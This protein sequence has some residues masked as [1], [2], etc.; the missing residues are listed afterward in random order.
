MSDRPRAGI[1]SRYVTSRLG[2][3]S[4]ASLP[5]RLIEYQLGWG[6]GGNVTSA[7]WQVSLCDPTWHVS[8]RSGVAASLTA[9]P[10][11][12]TTSLRKSYEFAGLFTAREPN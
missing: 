5:G 9:V 8:T 4:L 6:K 12:F 1:S 10:G 11:Y 7:G 3:L 2:Q